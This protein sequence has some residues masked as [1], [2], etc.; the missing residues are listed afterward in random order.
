MAL[1]AE[2]FT[3]YSRQHG[4]QAGA[5][6][7]AIKSPKVARELRN[8]HRGPKGGP[9]GIPAS[10]ILTLDGIFHQ[11]IQMSLAETSL[12]ISSEIA[13]GPTGRYFV[14]SPCVSICDIKAV[15]AVH[16]HSVATLESARREGAYR[17]SATP[18][19]VSERAVR[20][21]LR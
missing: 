3:A 8:G 16:S 4:V 12:A 13:T 7:S 17:S 14:L 11:G 15:I 20:E 1:G 21:G 10:A 5:P 2:P 9:A 6:L 19:T 18:V